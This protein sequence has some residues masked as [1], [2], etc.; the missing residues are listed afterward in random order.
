M[1][2]KL[3]LGNSMRGLDH[4]EPNTCHYGTANEVRNRLRDSKREAIHARQKI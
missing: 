3:E 1:A 4:R 2:Y